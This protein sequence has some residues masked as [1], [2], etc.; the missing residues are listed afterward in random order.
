MTLYFFAI[1]LSPKLSIG[2]CVNLGVYTTYPL[3]QSCWTTSDLYNALEKK[4]ASVPADTKHGKILKLSKEILKKA[5]VDKWSVRDFSTA[6]TPIKEELENYFKANDEYG[7]AIMAYSQLMDAGIP[8]ITEISNDYFLAQLWDPGDQIREINRK[9]GNL[10]PKLIS[11]AR[12]RNK[13]R[14]DRDNGIRKVV[15][16]GKGVSL[17]GVTIVNCPVFVEA[18]DLTDDLFK[19][20]KD[21]PHGLPAAAAKKIVELIFFGL[22]TYYDPEVD[23]AP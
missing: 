4:I 14:N 22:P 15:L 2:Y 17:A 13:L 19:G 21:G 11:L 6:P 1:I 10:E 7:K 23:L 12:S 9:I 5:Y 20:F 16:M 8:L 3:I 18:G